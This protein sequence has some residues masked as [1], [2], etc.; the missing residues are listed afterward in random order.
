MRE[1]ELH[2]HVRSQKRVIDGLRQRVFSLTEELAEQ[3]ALLRD[4]H[5]DLLA[6]DREVL[7]RAAEVERTEAR[8]A[9][10]EQTLRRLHETKAWRTIGQFWRA[11]AAGKR[12]L[13]IDR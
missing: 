8:A 3:R 13:R 2:E 12:L 6:R 1:K 7:D 4:A 11:K 5:E 10:V 9:E